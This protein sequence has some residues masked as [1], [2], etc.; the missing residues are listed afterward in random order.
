MCV[1]ALSLSTA[2][3]LGPRSLRQVEALGY[4]EV[5]EQGDLSTHGPLVSECFDGGEKC[6]TLPREHG[7]YA[8]PSR[9]VS[10]PP[11]GS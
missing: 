5:E 6:G 3:S 11:D 8:P 10:T 1:R 9:L 4:N 7:S 2:V